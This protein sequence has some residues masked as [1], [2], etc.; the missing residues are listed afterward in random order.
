MHIE[1]AVAANDS[2][3]IHDL[4]Y[5]FRQDDDIWRHAEMRLRPSQTSGTMGAAE[6]IDMV[7]SH[8]FDLATL[9]LSYA[10]WRAGRPAA[11]PTTITVDDVSVTTQSSSE[12]EVRRIVSLLRSAS[13][14]TS[15]DD[16]SAGQQQGQSASGDAG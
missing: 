12:E 2:T 11:P 10:T 13:P 7:L 3:V 5:W 9:V 6:T 8:G 4:Y 14:A 1:I 15:T 16:G